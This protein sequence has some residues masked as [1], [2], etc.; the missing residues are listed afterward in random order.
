MIPAV[1]AST[2]DSGAAS[3]RSTKLPKPARPSM[4]IPK[5]AASPT[6]SA[7]PGML[8]LNLKAALQKDSFDTIFPD[9]APSSP[10]S[11]SKV[12]VERSITE[13]RS[14]KRTLDG[15]DGPGLTAE[16]VKKRQKTATPPGSARGNTSPRSQMIKS[17]RAVA[18]LSA[19]A[20]DALQRRDTASSPASPRTKSSAD[21]AT[22]AQVAGELISE[23][24]AS[25]L[26]P[27]LLRPSILPQ[28]ASA[29]QWRSNSVPDI[30]SKPQLGAPS[31]PASSIQGHTGSGTNAFP[32]SPLTV[33]SATS[34]SAPVPDPAE[35][36][37][38][39]CDYGQ[40]GQLI[41][42]NG[43]P[44]SASLSGHGSSSTTL[45]RAELSIAAQ[46]Q[47]EAAA[48][49]TGVQREREAA[50]GKA[51]TGNSN[52]ATAMTNAQSKLETEVLVLELAFDS[53]AADELPGYLASLVSR[54]A[55]YRTV[56]AAQAAADAGPGFSKIAALTREALS[57]SLAAMETACKSGI[58]QLAD[59]KAHA[60]S[61]QVGTPQ[62]AGRTLMDDLNDLDDLLN[63]E[64]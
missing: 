18:D 59:E 55:E 64:I 42:G 62:P 13:V 34:H 11:R 6:K 3:P 9:S 27:N 26:P 8:S 39:D 1:T 16:H 32:P 38:T 25:A 37:F 29:P 58:A 15:A 48:A 4:A 28:S 36:T 20:K 21:D 33:P 45:I 2:G 49:Y 56:L 5:L 35:F 61:L 12:R 22:E 30:G 57:D 17:S 53:A 50:S 40:D 14:H 52:P 51:K 7:S 41:G 60:K 43:L 47:K 24:A 46:A 23:P 31:H 44:T 19:I 54:I 10:T 63:S